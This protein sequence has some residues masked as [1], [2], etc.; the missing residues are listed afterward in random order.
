MLLQQLPPKVLFVIVLPLFIRNCYALLYW[1]FSLTTST[2]MHA[3]TLLSTFITNVRNTLCYI[4]WKCEIDI[5]AF[6]ELFDDY[7]EITVGLGVILL[8]FMFL[9]TVS[10][11]FKACERFSSYVLVSFTNVLGGKFIAK[12]V[13]GFWYHWSNRIVRRG[14]SVRISLNWWN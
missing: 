2:S 5:V 14:R 8:L 7:S 10:I 4:S 13:R 1:F 12:N 6:V 11:L 3:T 9:L